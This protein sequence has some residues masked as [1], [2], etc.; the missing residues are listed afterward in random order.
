[1][2]AK[3]R[4]RPTICQCQSSLGKSPLGAGIGQG[5]HLSYLCEILQAKSCNN[6][7]KLRAQSDQHLHMMVLP[8]CFCNEQRRAQAKVRST[9]ATTTDG[10]GEVYL[11]SSMPERSLKTVSA[12]TAFE[13]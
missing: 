9:S 7:S 12:L 13:D 1:M 6:C 11:E 8:P 3:Y 5:C 4:R 10:S 2:R